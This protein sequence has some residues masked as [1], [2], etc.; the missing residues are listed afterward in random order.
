MVKIGRGLIDHGALKSG[1]SHKYSD[2][3]D[4]LIE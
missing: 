2:L 4:E 3:L 1:V